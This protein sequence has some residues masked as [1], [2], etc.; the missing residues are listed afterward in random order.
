MSCE[1]FPLIPHNEK[2]PAF[3]LFGNRLYTDQSPTEFLIELLLVTSSAKQVGMKGRSFTSPLPEFA[4][5]RAWPKTD[6]LRYAP[7]ARLNL[8]LFAFMGASRLDSRHETHREHYKELIERLQRSIRVTEAG[9]ENDVLRTLEN[10]FLGFQ[11]S[12][13]GRTWCAQ[14]FLP[15]C[16][17][18]LAGETIWNETAARRTPP[19]DWSGLL[20]RQG[21]YLTMN[22]HRFLARGGELLFLQLCNALGQSPASVKAWADQSG[23]CLETQEMDPAWLHAEL[24]RE[25]GR[26]LDQCPQTLTEIA[27]FLDN[28]IE[29]DTALATDTDGGRPRYVD[30]GWC[31]AESWKEGYLF[32]VE[33]LRLCTADLDVVERLQLLEAACA[34][35]V[36]RSLAAQSARHCETELQVAWPGY[37]LAVSAPVEDSSA[38][39]RISRH[40][41][42]VSERLIYHALRSGHVPLPSDAVQR[43]KVLKEADR[44]YGGKLF[45]GL[46]KRVGFLI[47]RRGAGVR[48]TLNEQ[49]L[50]L[51]VVTTVPVGGRLTY[52]RFKAL[53]EARHGLVFDSDGFAR[54]DAWTGGTGRV[55]LGNNIDAWLQEMLAAAGLL[56]H[57]SDSCALVDNPAAKKGVNS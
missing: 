47:P 41:A 34:M 49:L 56:I 16:P 43:E 42:K 38:V 14:S 10:L 1:I 26:V 28:G 8:K 39:K 31:A 2:N 37:R 36:L 24:Q 55:S 29:A 17:G 21:D 48:F 53:V 6:S 50:R 11:G 18:L 35:Q 22:K 15:I 23:V 25:L 9:A 5:L 19:G 3:L 54:A 20:D 12:G 13:S 33:L 52:D 44:R 40:T 45:S 4:L 46:A 30:A 27:D 51:L 57:L 7:R 32:A